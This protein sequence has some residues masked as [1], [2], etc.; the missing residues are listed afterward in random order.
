MA[1]NNIY[2]GLVHYPVYNKFGDIVTTSIT[3]MDVHDI[4]RTCLTYG[5]KKYF[6]INPLASQKDLYQKIIGFWNSETGQN[7]QPDRAS[8]LQQI[9]FCNTL[10]E[11]ISII[12][13]QEN[14]EPLLVTTT[15]RDTKGQ[16]AYGDFSGIV[17]DKPVLLLFGTG[18]GL[19]DE[20]HSQSDFTLKPIKITDDYNHLSVR[21]AVAIILDRLIPKNTGGI[22]GYTASCKQRAN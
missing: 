3:N 14:A 21:S 5:V 7:Y 17:G 2:L 4:S 18:Y 6:L 12:K 9:Q 19:A 10:Q 8:A 15:A 13:T 1:A 11:A 16:V 22:D 20:I